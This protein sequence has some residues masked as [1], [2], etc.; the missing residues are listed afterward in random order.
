M[1]EATIRVGVKF[2]APAMPAGT[3]SH[4]PAEL[5]TSRIDIM[6]QRSAASA[7]QP[8]FG[9]CPTCGCR[10][11]IASSS[12]MPFCSERCQQVDL[13]RWLGEEIGLPHE[14]DPGETPVEYR[15]EADA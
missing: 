15:D 4:P 9:A 11:P 12:S 8:A 14:G 5:A 6:N 3:C 13:G 10:F 2:E 1:R 7:N